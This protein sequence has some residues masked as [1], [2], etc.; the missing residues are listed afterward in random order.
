MFY[1]DQRSGFA[2]VIS[3]GMLVIV[4]SYGV[5]AEP[6]PSTLDDYVTLYELRSYELFQ[7]DSREFNRRIERGKKAIRRMK[8]H[9]GRSAEAATRLWFETAVYSNDRADELPGLPAVAYLKDVDPSINAK[10]AAPA[11]TKVANTRVEEETNSQLPE[12]TAQ[13]EEKKQRIQFSDAVDS[14]T[15]AVTPTEDEFEN[16]KAVVTSTT[17]VLGDLA[18]SVFSSLGDATSNDATSTDHPR[19]QDGPKDFVDVGPFP[20]VQPT[21]ESSFDAFALTEA[22]ESSTAESVGDAPTVDLNDRIAE[23][24]ERVEKVQAD[25]LVALGG[26]GSDGELGAV[27]EKIENLVDMQ[28]GIQVQQELTSHDTQ[29][30]QAMGDLATVAEELHKGIFKFPKSPEGLP[31]KRAVRLLKRL[32]NVQDQLSELSSEA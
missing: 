11:E 28:S 14:L 23:F 8:K 17:N 31:F 20:E 21:T 22:D 19:S 1:R 2:K 9:G 27:V 18:S 30:V 15:K 24:N 25:V 7:H 5:A 16:A 29:A 3:V 4:S 10:A 26:D 32:E 12:A 13:D 6:Y